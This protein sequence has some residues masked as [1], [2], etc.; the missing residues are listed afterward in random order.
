MK[1]D[2]HV[3]S[4]YSF[5]SYLNPEK[6]IHIAKKKGLDGIAITDHNTIKG[7]LNALK[8]KCDGL[9]I[10]VGSEITTEIGDVLGLFL[11]EE[12]KSN[13]YLEVIDEIRD[14]N[15]IAILAHPFKNV[16]FLD[17]DILLKVDALEGFNARVKSSNEKIQLLSL[18]NKFPLT[19]GSDAHFYFEIGRGVTM[20]N[21]I[22]DFED[23]RKAIIS[24]N[25]KIYGKTSSAY[26]STGSKIIKSLKARRLPN[27]FSRF[28]KFF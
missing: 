6:I 15:G 3:H 5:D 13:N 9:N 16:N 27:K 11:N 19:A 17:D 26:V 10:I 8:Y 4:K 28:T 12:I 22:N 25:T 24:G 21:N 18:K 2:L 20:L 1:F 7:G 23:I 14:Q